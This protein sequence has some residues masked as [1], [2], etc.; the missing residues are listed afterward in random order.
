MAIC[1]A[2]TIPIYY[3]LVIIQNRNLDLIG[4]LIPISR[5]CKRIKIYV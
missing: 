4:H 3:G 1:K 2:K 5:L